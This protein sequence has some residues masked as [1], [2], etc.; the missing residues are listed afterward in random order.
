M[1]YESSDYM[2]MTNKTVSPPP[3]PHRERADLIWS[4]YRMGTYIVEWSNFFL[5]RMQALEKEMSL[6]RWVSLRNI[7]GGCKEM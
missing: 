6:E 2:N 4:S 3:A 1:I 7:I 5:E